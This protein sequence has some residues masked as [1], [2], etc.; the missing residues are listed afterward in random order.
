MHCI[1]PEPQLR[2]PAG[3][4]HRMCGQLSKAVAAVHAACAAERT[5]LL[6][7]LMPWCCCR[8]AWGGCRDQSAAADPS[9]SSS[10]NL[11]AQQQTVGMML[12]GAQSDGAQH[13]RAT[14]CDRAGILTPSRALLCP[15]NIDRRKTRHSSTSST[16]QIVGHSLVTIVSCQPDVRLL[17]HRTSAGTCSLEVWHC[18]AGYVTVRSKLLMFGSSA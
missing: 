2:G 8:G 18:P 17:C 13:N 15:L 7:G 3:S 1:A 12:H 14:S 6:A 10:R 16:L 9:A 4:G 11:D 5:R